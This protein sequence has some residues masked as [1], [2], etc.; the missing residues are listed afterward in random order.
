MG[1][2]QKKLWENRAVQENCGS[3][4]ATLEEGNGARGITASDVIQTLSR[5]T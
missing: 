5:V 1:R 3:G 4:F 2:R